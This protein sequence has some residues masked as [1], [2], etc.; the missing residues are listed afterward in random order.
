MNANDKNEIVES[1][2]AHIDK[3]LSEMALGFV[4]GQEPLVTAVVGLQSQIDDARKSI[5]DLRTAFE[6][7]CRKVSENAESEHWEDDG[8]DWKNN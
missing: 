5:E 6:M 2:K 7:F 8:E 3:R 4:S 1:L